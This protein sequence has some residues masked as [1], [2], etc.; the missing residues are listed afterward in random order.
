MATQKT[1]AG[2]DRTRAPKTAQKTARKTAQKTGAPQRD[3]TS[4]ARAP[5]SEEAADIARAANGLSEYYDTQHEAVQ[6]VMKAQMDVM[7][8]MM[9]ASMNATT[10]SLKAMAAFWASAIPGTRRRGND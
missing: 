1:P 8:T 9:S 6:G 5:A 10:T 3:R 4:R 7:N 2:T